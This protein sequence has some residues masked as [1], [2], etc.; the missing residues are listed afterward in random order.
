[1]L[2]TCLEKSAR[3]SA[4]CGVKVAAQMLQI[5][6]EEV[7][8]PN[9]DAEV[10]VPN[11]MLQTCLSLL[12][13]SQVAVPNVLHKVRYQMG[14]FN[15]AFRKKWFQIGCFLKVWRS[16]LGCFKVVW[17]RL[18]QNCLEKVAVPTW[19]LQIALRE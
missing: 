14:C 17:K 7:V 1:M 16:Q 3:S 12:K 8:V 10:A 6:L 19:M 15:V 9:W 2:Q 4:K 11:W 18:L 13:K 5:C